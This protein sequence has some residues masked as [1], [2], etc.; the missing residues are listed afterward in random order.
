MTRSSSPEHLRAELDRARTLGAQETGLAV[1]TTLRADNTTH[2]SIVNAG[3]LAHPLT[4]EPVIAFV[5]RGAVLKLR[6]LRA[7]PRAT[8]VFRSGWDWVAID[9]DAELAGPDDPMDGLDAA[10]TGR[11]LRAVY[12]AAA[13]GTPD[14]WASLDD[15]VTAE[16]HTAVLIRPRRAYPTE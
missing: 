2:S 1:V 13:G 16:R 15:A 8:I 6:H 7:R 5:S 9:G 3:V 11:L 4:G 14:D 10:A 12:A